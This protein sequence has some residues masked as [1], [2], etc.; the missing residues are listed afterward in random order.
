MRLTGSLL[1]LFTALANGQSPANARYS[2]EQTAARL[3]ADLA[4]LKDVRAAGSPSLIRECQTARNGSDQMVST[5]PAFACRVASDFLLAESQ[6]PHF[7][8]RA[9]SFNLVNVLAGRELEPG[10]L[11]FLANALVD[12]MAIADRSVEA[13]VLVSDS[14]AFRDAAMRSYVAMEALGVNSDRA[15]M[16]IADFV[17]SA[18]ALSRPPIEPI[19]PT[20]P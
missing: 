4:N 2:R 19:P 10:A 16:L 12:A 18:E 9:F 20:H 7:P 6:P 15:R 17:R 1:V 13:R 11:S 14:P 8:A 3:R 5:L